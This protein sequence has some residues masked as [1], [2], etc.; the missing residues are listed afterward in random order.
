MPLSFKIS[1]TFAL[2]LISHP[3]VCILFATTD[4]RLSRSFATP[5]SNKTFCPLEA[6]TKNDQLGIVGSVPRPSS[7]G[8]TR[9][10]MG[11]LAKRNE[12]SMMLTLAVAPGGTSNCVLEAIMLLLVAEEC[13]CGSL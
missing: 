7:G 5:R 8:L 2:I 10:S 6:S 11:M 1:A 9:S 13:C 3:D 12:E 4:A